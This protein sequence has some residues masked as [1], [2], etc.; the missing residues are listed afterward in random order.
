MYERFENRDNIQV[1]CVIVDRLISV[2]RNWIISVTPLFTSPNQKQKLLKTKR[3]LVVSTMAQWTDRVVQRPAQMHPKEAHST[4][5][6]ERWKWTK[7]HVVQQ[8]VNY[9]AR[10][11]FMPGTHNICSVVL[12]YFCHL[13]FGVVLKSVYIECTIAVH[14]CCEAVA[15]YRCTNQ[16]ELS[17]HTLCQYAGLLWTRP[18]P[19]V[20]TAL[21]TQPS[22]PLCRKGILICSFVAEAGG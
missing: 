3:K 20:V 6:P 12:N 9:R 15:E 7:L 17:L 19:T 5:T 14:C 1:S 18:P 13:F 22:A 8:R 11:S 4:P 2:F 21:L 10:S 16:S